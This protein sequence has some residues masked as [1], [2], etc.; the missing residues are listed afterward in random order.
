MLLMFDGLTVTK[1]E[2]PDMITTPTSKTEALRALHMFGAELTQAT[3][4]GR[5][6]DPHTAEET[7]AGLRADALEAGATDV[8]AGTVFAAGMSWEPFTA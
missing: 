5:P 2:E 6:L 3:E 4:D 1:P 7:W 8:E